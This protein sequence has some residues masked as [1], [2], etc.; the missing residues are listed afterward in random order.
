MSSTKN[1]V[2]LSSYIPAPVFEKFR[3]RADRNS[4]SIA[5]EIYALIKEALKQDEEALQEAE[6]VGARS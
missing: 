6:P 1:T 3:A 2:Q 5:K 4:R